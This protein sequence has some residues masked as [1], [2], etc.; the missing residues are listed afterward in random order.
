M[1]G[2][3]DEDDSAAVIMTQ[4]AGEV[5]DRG[6]ADLI[7]GGGGNE[8]GDGGVPAC[9]HLLDRRLLIGE[10][11][12]LRHIRHGEPVHSAVGQRSDAEAASVPDRLP[13]LAGQ[14]HRH[15]GDAPPRG[16]PGVPRCHRF[17]VDDGADP[18]VQ[19]VGADDEVE[20]L[21]LRL[22][23]ARIVGGPGPDSQ[24]PVGAGRRRLG[25]GAHCPGSQSIEEDAVEVGP[26]DDAQRTDRIIGHLSDPVP[27]CAALTC[28]EAFD[29]GVGHGVERLAQTERLQCGKPVGE[30]RQSRTT[31]PHFGGTFEHGD[32]GAGP[33]QSHGRRESADSSSDDSDLHELIVARRTPGGDAAG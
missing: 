26:V 32:L 29:A 22:H 10:D 9:E 5:G 31:G 28:G 18:A 4:P 6:A 20:T 7:G 16:I 27:V 2:I 15:R 1:C 14:I 8:I 21:C 33:L 24:R 19:T 11:R 25:A 17:T 12:V 23:R 13:G 30:D 3:A